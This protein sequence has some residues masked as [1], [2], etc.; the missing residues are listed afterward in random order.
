MFVV[1]VKSEDYQNCCRVAAVL[2]TTVVHNGTHTHTHVSRQ[3]LHLHV[4]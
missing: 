4:H 1:E 2:C 3:L